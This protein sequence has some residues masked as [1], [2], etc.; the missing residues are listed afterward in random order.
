[1]LK[2]NITHKATQNN[3][4]HITH[5]EY[6]RKQAKLSLSARDFELWMNADRY[7][8]NILHQDAMRG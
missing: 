4:G 6:K 5:T 1:M 8:S 7:S 2:Q 3:K